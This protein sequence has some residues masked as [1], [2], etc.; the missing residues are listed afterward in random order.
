[1]EIDV[2]MPNMTKNKDSRQIINDN[3]FCEIV[4]CSSSE[5]VCVII[6]NKSKKDIK[7][8]IVNEN[9]EKIVEDEHIDLNNSDKCNSVTAS[10][11]IESRTN[12]IQ[13]Q[14][15][16]L[17]D[18]DSET[19]NYLENIEPRIESESFP[20]RESLH[21]TFEETFFLMFGLGCLRLIHFDSTLMD[22][23]SAWLYFCKE[24]EN[25]IQKYVVYHYF[26]SKG[27]VVKPGLKYGGDFRQY[28]FSFLCNLDK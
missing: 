24:D 22:I 10:M 11:N 16:I 7:K 9:D 28:Y 3:E 27:W 20:V 5:D 15:L 26:R 25:F 17:P 14:L 21:M 23:N 12:D 8:S 13:G 19:E 18:S 4:P 6:N 1:M 2:N